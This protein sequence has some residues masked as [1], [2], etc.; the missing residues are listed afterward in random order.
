VKLS[1]GRPKKARLQENG[2]GEKHTGGKRN[3]KEKESCFLKSKYNE[4]GAN[5]E[6]EDLIKNGK[7]PEITEGLPSLKREKT[8]ET[9]TKREK[10]SI[11]KLTGFSDL[12]KRKS[13]RKV[14]WKKKVQENSVVKPSMRGFGG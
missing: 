9:L 5:W 4:G 6:G 10:K 11:R 13:T 8:A 3:A 1:H 2:P 14:P 12:S 7:K